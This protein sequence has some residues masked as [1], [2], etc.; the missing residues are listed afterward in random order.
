MC[1]EKVREST[2]LYV[3][4]LI[5]WSDKFVAGGAFSQKRQRGR[6]RD[7]HPH[8]LRCVVDHAKTVSTF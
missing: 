5:S 7:I 4:M 3:I 1:D 8:K 2:G 6:C